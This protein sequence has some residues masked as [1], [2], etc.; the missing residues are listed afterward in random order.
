MRNHSR[1]LENVT[2]LLAHWLEPNLHHASISH[3]RYSL[4]PTIFHDSRYWKKLSQFWI[5][6]NISLEDLKNRMRALIIRLLWVTS[7]RQPRE[8]P[9][10]VGDNSA[11]QDICLLMEAFGVGPSTGQYPMSALAPPNDVKTS[12]RRTL[13]AF[14]PRLSQ[15]TSPEI[16]YYHEWLTGQLGIARPPIELKQALGLSGWFAG[17][18]TSTQQEIGLRV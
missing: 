12:A 3:N 13:I 16:E 14:F 17:M 9:L 11:L 15:H 1:F 18:S 2:Q 5:F 4:H 8:F 10:I 7:R 6:E